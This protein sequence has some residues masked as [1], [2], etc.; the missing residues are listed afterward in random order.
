[1]CGCSTVISLLPSPSPEESSESA[2][3]PEK[4]PVK[5]PKDPAKQEE[6]SEVQEESS[7]VSEEQSDAAD[8]SSAANDESSAET[9]EAG[10]DP[11]L[12]SLR[13]A[14]V[15]TPEAFAVAYFGFIEEFPGE[16]GVVVGNLC[17]Q[18]GDNLPFLYQIPEEQVIGTQGEIYCI[19]PTDVNATVAVNLLSQDEEGNVFPDE[20]LYRSEVGEPIVLLCNYGGFYPDCVVYITDSEGKSTEFYPQLNAYGVC[21]VPLNEKEELV[22]FDFTDYEAVQGPYFF[23]KNEGW[24]PPLKAGLDNTS[25]TLYAYRDDG[26]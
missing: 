1:M 18:L 8:E 26:V 24:L 11:S 5:K 20:V 10:F 17:P 22:G 4:T 15:G 21:D 7:A 2:S 25:W 9:E 16:F 13:Q 19:V 3:E 12:V 14:M 6:Q 23:W